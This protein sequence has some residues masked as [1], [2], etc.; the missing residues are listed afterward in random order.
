LDYPYYL[1]RDRL[2]GAEGDSLE[3]VKRGEGKIL[4]LKGR[5]VAAYRNEKGAVTLRSPECTHL[6]CI[7]RWNGAD[8]TWDCPCH[9]SRFTTDGEVVAG[10]AEKPLEKVSAKAEFR[11]REVV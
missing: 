10:P 5:N 6:G 1:L 8:D 3:D 7:V 11:E 9:G 2:R 4:R